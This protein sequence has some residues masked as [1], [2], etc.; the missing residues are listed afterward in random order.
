[1]RRKPRILTVAVGAAGLLAFTACD[2]AV[3]TTNDTTYG[4]SADGHSQWATPDLRFFDDA[5]APLIHFELICTV[6]GVARWVR[7][8]E[9]NVASM[10]QGQTL[11][12]W[13]EGSSQS[14][15]V[16]GRPS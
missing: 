15:Q 14:Q 4:H 12:L 3:D 9:F 16:T 13:C 2:E 7:S 1:M 8:G 5:G 11:N 6:N 10:Y